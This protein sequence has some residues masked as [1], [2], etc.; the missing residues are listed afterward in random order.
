MISNSVMK[1]VVEKLRFAEKP[2]T[3]KAACDM[4]GIAYNTAR[5][6][7]LVNEYLEE[8]ER[9]TTR[10]LANK[11]K[12]ASDFEI[13]TIIEDYLSLE[14]ISSIAERISRTPVFVK[15]VLTNCGIPLRDTNTSYFNPQLL[16]FDCV[17]E[18]IADGSV[19]YS[20]KHQEI[21]T[22]KRKA[23]TAEGTAYWVYLG[24]EQNVALMWYDILPLDYLINRYK[25]KLQTSSGIKASDTLSQTLTK[26]LKHEKM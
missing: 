14:A 13:S 11:G 24:S 10:F 16:P 9:K 17:T 21:G 19:V 18:E 26:A 12:P 6:D 25:L 4:L 5:L 23:K 2:I 7:K 20:A 3:K 8:K 15:N 1:S 22:I